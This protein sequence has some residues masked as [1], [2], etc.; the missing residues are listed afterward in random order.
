[1]KSYPGNRLWRP[2][3]LRDVEAF[4][5][6]RRLVTDGGKAVSH[7]LPPG[8]FLVLFCYRLSQLQD[9]SANG[10]IKAS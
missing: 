7:L 2:I 5:F 9:S 4:K 6:S 8:T 3:G 1:M 10:R